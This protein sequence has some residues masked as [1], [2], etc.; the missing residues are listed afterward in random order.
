MA[1]K[2]QELLLN[3]HPP[4]LHS[5]STFTLHFAAISLFRNLNFFP[6]FSRLLFDTSARRRPQTLPTNIPPLNHFAIMALTLFTKFV[7]AALAC[8]HIAST[9]NNSAFPFKSVRLPL[10]PLNFSSKAD[11]QPK[12]P[13][14]NLQPIYFVTYLKDPVSQEDGYIFL[15]PYTED[16]SLEYQLDVQATPVVYDIHDSYLVRLRDS[17]NRIHL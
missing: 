1:G 10:H 17:R 14:L 6:F 12:R 3:S 11:V 15:S 16:L 13:G 2:W 9:W 7:C 4:F 5:R 8:A